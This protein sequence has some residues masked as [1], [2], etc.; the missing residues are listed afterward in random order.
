M[1]RHFDVQV[2]ESEITPFY[3]TGG[4][5]NYDRDPY[6]IKYKVSNYFFI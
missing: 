6:T 4:G 1:S 5:V 2:T 3:G